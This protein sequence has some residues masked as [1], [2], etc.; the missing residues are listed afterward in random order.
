MKVNAARWSSNSCA[1]LLSHGLRTLRHS[2]SIYVFASNAF[3]P[4]Q[5][6]HLRASPLSSEFVNREI[7]RSIP[8]QD[9]YLIPGILFSSLAPSS[10]SFHPPTF[11]PPPS[12]LTRHHSPT[13]LSQINCQ[14]T[15]IQLLCKGR[16]A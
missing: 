11:L 8:R 15:Q 2:S 16:S 10:S 6:K 13:S 3:E 5:H 9:D 12:L 7:D 1:E 14:I 4:L